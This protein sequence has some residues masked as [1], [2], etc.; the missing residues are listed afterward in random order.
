M[1]NFSDRYVHHRNLLQRGK[2]EIGL[3]IA[4][5]NLSMLL[6]VF[7]RTIMHLTATWIAFSVVGC[8]I[9]ILIFCYSIGRFCDKNNI[10]SKEL[11]WN[12]KRNE[13]LQSLLRDVQI[14]K[15][16]TKNPSGDI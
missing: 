13:V 7:L 8:V 5:F 14:I 15:E 16:N 6:S 10:I 9:G 4:I 1:I 11:G 2:Q 12:N 3:Y